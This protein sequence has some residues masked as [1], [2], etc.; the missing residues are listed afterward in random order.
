MHPQYNEMPNHDTEVMSVKDWL[1]VYLISIIPC[2]NIVMLFVWAFSGSGNLN[3][4]NWARAALIVAAIL[5]VLSFLLSTIM[6][7]ALVALLGGL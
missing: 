4:K 2:V 6:T 7:A 1:I 5:I 3:R